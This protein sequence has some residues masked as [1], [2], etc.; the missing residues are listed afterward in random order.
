M[1]KHNAETRRSRAG[2]TLTELLVVLGI[3]GIVMG[4]IAPVI[5]RVRKTARDT[6]CKSNLRQLYNGYK[7]YVSDN[8]GKPPMVQNR[9][10]LGLS[11]LPG[12]A[13]ILKP[14]VGEKV[15]RCPLDHMEFYVTDGT[16]YE[17]NVMI[18]GRMTEE[19]NSMIAAIRRATDP[20]AVPMFYD[21][22][23]F[24]GPKDSG[25]GKNAVYGDGHV[26]SL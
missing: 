13:D 19:P 11:K 20:A 15:L 17:L 26:E 18:Y 16:S 6:H 5:L 9:P 22:E 7:I 23:P 21:Y 3:A 24:H 10:S 2:V 4:L 1:K 14:Y 12:V 8:A 25:H